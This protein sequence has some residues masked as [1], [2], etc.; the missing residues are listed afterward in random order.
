MRTREWLKEKRINYSLTQAQLAK[1]IGVSTFTIENI[2][3]GKRLGSVDTWEKIEKYFFNEQE[4]K[5]SYDS[6]GL[7]FELK[8]DIEEF[9]ENEPCILVYKVIDN[10]IFFTNYDFVIKE[11]PFNPD[12]ELDDDEFFIE[13]NLKYALEV[14][15]KQN[16]T[17]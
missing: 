8:E 15:E 13:T 1:E 11:D 10:R 5:I 14:F 9:G 4:L 2:E 7:I 16:E 17:I 6:E 12:K 3:Q